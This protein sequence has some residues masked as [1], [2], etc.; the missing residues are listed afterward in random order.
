MTWGCLAT[1]LESFTETKHWAYQAPS[2]H[3]DPCSLLGSPPHQQSQLQLRQGPSNPQHH[4]GDNPDLTLDPMTTPKS[5]PRV[6]RDLHYPSMPG[7][8]GFSELDPS[9]Q[10]GEAGVP[11]MGPAQIPEPGV[12][13]P[14]RPHSRLSSSAATPSPPCSRALATVFV[15]PSVPAL[16]HWGGRTA[17]RGH[18]QGLGQAAGR[19]ELGLGCADCWSEQLCLSAGRF[20][21]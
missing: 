9:V 11:K 16:S 7:P 17:L 5:V 14:L 18:T 21:V 10:D 1:Y 13:Q 15:R 4:S 8:R 6:H 2:G 12:M 19:T 3:T 20:L